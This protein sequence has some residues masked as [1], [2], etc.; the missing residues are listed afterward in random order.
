MIINFKF[1][2]IH[3]N[4]SVCFFDWRL[5]P[6]IICLHT[7]KTRSKERINRLQNNHPNLEPYN[8]ARSI[9]PPTTYFCQIT[10]G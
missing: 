7:F 3:L 9:L 8:S 10:C 1:L 4:R 5:G 6:Q 2:R